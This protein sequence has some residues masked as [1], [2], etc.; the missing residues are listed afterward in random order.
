MISFLR[1]RLSLEPR[2]SKEIFR[3]G[4]DSTPI[5]HVY[6]LIEKRLIL[7]GDQYNVERNGYLIINITRRMGMGKESIVG[8]KGWGA[9]IERLQSTS[10]QF[11]E[12]PNMD[13]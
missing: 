3:T 5:V 1:K 10:L 4:L 7:Q 8:M 13:T 12:E 9:T 11:T 6:F 2:V